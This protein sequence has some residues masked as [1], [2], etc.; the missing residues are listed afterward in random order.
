MTKKRSIEEEKFD[1][2]KAAYD[3]IFQIQLNGNQ[4]IRV[5]ENSGKN[6]KMSFV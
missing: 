5:D 6:L 4:R 1:F 2:S 3:C